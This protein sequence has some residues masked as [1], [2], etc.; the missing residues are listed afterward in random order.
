MRGIETDGVCPEFS[1]R[2]R[3]CTKAATT[4]STPPSRPPAKNSPTG[5]REINDLSRYVVSP[6]TE[7]RLLP[8]I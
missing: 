5:V 2:R 7:Q 8:R 6:Y 3:V 4:T 1:P